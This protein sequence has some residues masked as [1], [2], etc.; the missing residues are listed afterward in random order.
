MLRDLDRV[1]A[2]YDRVDQCPAGIGSSNGSV[3]LQDRRKLADCLGCC[4]PVRHARDAMWQADI[5]IEACAIAL[6]AAVNLAVC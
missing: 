2:L 1:R 6:A 4:R 3:T 5:A